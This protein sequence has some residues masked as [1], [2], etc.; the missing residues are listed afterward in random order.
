M[1]VVVVDLEIGNLL[2]IVRGLE[3]CGAKVKVT[4]DPEV[5]LNSSHVVL[6]GDGAFKFA[7]DQIKKRNLLNT[8]KS[9]NKS[10]SNL[11]GICIGM[12]IL[13]E[14]SEKLILKDQSNAL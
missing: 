4:S 7:M 1:N 3:Y 14:K 9:F 11:L 12:Q 10:K 2:S 6:P 8:L 13:F 5:I